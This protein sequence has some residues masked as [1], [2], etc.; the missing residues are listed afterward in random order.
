MGVNMDNQ[1]AEKDIE[2]LDPKDN[3]EVKYKVMLTVHLLLIMM[4]NLIK[5]SAFQNEEIETQSDGFFWQS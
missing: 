4:N 1:L 5:L 3:I 2:V